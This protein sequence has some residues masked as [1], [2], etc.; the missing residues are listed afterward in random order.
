MNIIMII[1]LMFIIYYVADVYLQNLGRTL[2]VLFN[3]CI[4]ACLVID[5]FFIKN[6]EVFNYLFAIECVNMLLIGYYLVETPLRSIYNQIAKIHAVSIILG[7]EWIF[8][9]KDARKILKEFLESN[10][11]LYNSSN[12]IGLVLFS[13]TGDEIV[14]TLLMKKE[15]HKL[16]DHLNNVKNKK[17]SQSGKIISICL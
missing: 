4:L 12:R 13:R 10:D 16:F 11:E 2:I 15:N 6:Q 1:I 5:F 8:Q 9:A 17:I 7:F 14:I 3:V